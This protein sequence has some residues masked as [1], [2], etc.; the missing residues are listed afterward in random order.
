MG[1]VFVYTVETDRRKTPMVHTK[2]EIVCI[3]YISIYLC[4][5]C[6]ELVSQRDWHEVTHQRA[7]FFLEIIMIQF[8]LEFMLTSNYV[9]LYG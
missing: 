9:N 1:L 7:P 2:K 3:L 6:L 5:P 4:N 8:F